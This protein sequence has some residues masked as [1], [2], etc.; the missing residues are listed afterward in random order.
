MTWEEW[1]ESKYNT[2]GLVD[3]GLSQIKN[4]NKFLR[5]NQRFIYIDEIIDHSLNYSLD[6][7]SDGS[8]D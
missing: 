5:E 1:L 6:V 8:N 3:S 4:G 7:I 2:L